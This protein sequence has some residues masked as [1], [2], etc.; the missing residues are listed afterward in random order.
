MNPNSLSRAT[1]QGGRHAGPLAL[2]IAILQAPTV[3]SAEVSGATGANDIADLK[4]A[5]A[6]MR[7]QYEARID[8]LEVRIRRAEVKAASAETRASGNAARIEAQAEQTTYAAQAPVPT[9]GAQSRANAFNPAISLVL[10]GTGAAYSRNPDD[11]HLPGFQAGGEAGLKSEG[12]SLD[13]TE[14]TA[15]ASVDNWFYGQ[16]TLG[17]HQ[18]EG[19]TEVHVEEAFLDSLSLPGG[20]GVRLGRFFPEVGYGNTKHAHAWDFV[21]APLTGQA[22]LGKQY[23]DDGVRLS[24]LAPVDNYLEFGVE[25]L[26]GEEFPAS[27]GSDQILGGAQNWFARFGADVG[28]DHSFLVGLSHLR[29]KPEGRSSGHSHEGGEETFAFTGDSNLTAASLVWKWAPE[30]NTRYRNLVLQGEYFHRDEE[31][32]IDFENDTGTALLPYDG[33]QRGAYVQG[34]YQFLPGWRAG[35][36][37]DRLWTDN[38]LRV[39]GGNTSGETADDLMEESGLLG[40]HDPHRWTLMTDYSNSEFSRLRFQYA[41]DYSVSNDGDDQFLIQYIT[42]FGS[43]GAHTY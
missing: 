22:F 42:S 41:R 39:A 31:G 15:S 33:T 6:D 18:H 23:H 25:A 27:G 35:V 7:Q 20:L 9:G 21:D 2:A 5:L 17:L 26:R 38:E 36:R 10:Q 19:E 28:T 12:L 1:R 11:W 34:V 14:L 16:A 3:L 8:A 37:Y 40:E 24:W 29:A 32:R 4:R 43:H 30:G 13:E